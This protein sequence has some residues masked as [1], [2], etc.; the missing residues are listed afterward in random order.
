MSFVYQPS[1]IINDKYRITGIL[2]KGGVAITY[3]AIDLKTDTTA[4]IKVVSLKQLDNWKQVEL[5]Q[6]EAE[7]LKQLEHP[8]IPRYI[9]YFDIETK[10]DK[11]FYLVQQIAPGKSLDRL[12][13][14]GWR[15]SE[16][17]VKD[18]ARQVLNIL[19]YLHSLDPPVVHR[20]LKPSNLIRDDDG[21][22]YLV[23]FGAVQNTYYNTLMQGSTVVGTYG[24]MSPEQF[25]GQAFPATDL[26]SLGAT[27][28]YLLTHRSP[29]E[30]PHDTLKL[31]F[32]NSVDLDD[33]FADWLEKILEPDIENRFSDAE[34]ALAEL[35]KSKKKK[36]RKF[37]A[38][39]SAI[40]LTLGLITGFNSYKWFF[41]SNIGFYPNNWCS[42][43][44]ADI[45]FKQGGDIHIMKNEEKINVIIC[46]IKNTESDY[47][48][49]YLKNILKDSIKE[50]RKTYKYQYLNNNK[51]LIDTAI[52]EKKYDII[53]L[54]IAL[55]ADVNA[56]VK[57]DRTPLFQA[58]SN[59][60][61]DVV[62]LLIDNGADV[63]AT[64]SSGNH[65]LFY[66][67]S[68]G[69][70][71][72]VLKDRFH[73]IDILLKN[74]ANPNVKNQRG[75]T[76]LIV[77]II[78]E[79][80]DV[81]KLLIDNG[82]DVN[83][84]ID[85]GQT[86]LFYALEQKKEKF[87]KLLINNG[88]DANI[89]NDKNYF[90]KD[91]KVA[92]LDSEKLPLFNRNNTYETAKI[93]IDSGA[94]INVKNKLGK[95]P[96]F[97]YSSLGKK[98]IVEYLI[99][100]GANVNTKNNFGQTPLFEVDNKEIAKLLIINKANVNIKDKYG[101]TPL[102]EAKNKEIAQLLI[103][104]GADVNTRDK[105]GRNPLFGVRDK[106]VAQLLINN[107][108]D[109]YAKDKYGRTPLFEARNKSAIQ[110]LIDLGLDFKTKDKTGRNVLFD[111]LDYKTAKLFLDLGVDIN[112]KDNFGQTVLFTAKNEYYINF[113]IKLGADINAQNSY[114][115]TALFDSVKNNNKYKTN[116]LI[117]K[118][119]DVN[120][121]N[122]NGQTPLFFA[123]NKEIFQ[124][125]VNNDANLS[126]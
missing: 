22:I 110:L 20:D 5:F 17:E 40:A 75:D 2:G 45:F 71:K 27:L 73:S 108:A 72:T 38:S 57:Y 116:I 120:H 93:I 95:T 55:G 23:D 59:N 51:S 19:S 97:F 53:P 78:S 13:E 105:Q 88:A 68:Y 18:I 96:L 113:F 28:L 94:D 74:G 64:D 99:N 41:L 85:S 31:D 83:M 87:V 10:T 3:S 44:T 121:R 90:K 107:G 101:R 1:E 115:E 9:D 106:D 52:A 118:G 39:V 54:L 4:A 66:A 84:K 43:K 49:K 119:L 82:V 16:E 25:R 117:K 21:K 126:I 76:L 42:P 11:A 104:N 29:A 30:L 123:N 34:V 111:I 77:A 109:I 100:S 36:Q 6:R 70:T 69:H 63:N 46:I 50:T 79:R 103:D 91:P 124:L 14:S 114:G 92:L 32:R 56:R 48:K 102:F 26:Y 60:R 125:L 112:E 37:I 47:I 15:A 80:L 24:Y 98:N 35:F 89:K 65:I 81:A 67:F 8:A 7:I 58:I 61:P 122:N 12:V 62:K 33:S 86:P